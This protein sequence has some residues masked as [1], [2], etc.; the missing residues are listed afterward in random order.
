MD[1]INHWSVLQL[2]PSYFMSYTTAPHSG[3][4]FSEHFP[5]GCNLKVIIP[6]KLW[7]N[8]AHGKKLTLKMNCLPE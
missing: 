4:Q 2:I 8:K 6:M 1:D 3:G 7:K 5:N